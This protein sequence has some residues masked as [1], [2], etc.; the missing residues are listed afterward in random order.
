MQQNAPQSPAADDE[1]TLVELVQKIRAFFRRVWREKRVVVYCLLFTITI[2]LV[3]AFGSTK[4]YSAS[5]RIMPYRAASSSGGLGGLAGL[6]GIKIPSRG[7]EETV[8]PEMYPDIA[9]SLDFRMAMS[10]TPLYFRSLGDYVTPVTYFNEHAEPSFADGVK[11]YTIGLP[12]LV[13]GKVI[14]WFKSEEEVTG[15]GEDPTPYLAKYPK[16][17]LTLVSSIGERLTVEPEMLKGFQVI[18]SLKI[19]AT[20]PDPEAAAGLTKIASDQLMESVIQFEIRKI[21]GE[22]EYLETHHEEMEKRYHRAQAALAKFRDRTRNTTS[23]ATQ[24][25]MERLQNE[26]NMAFDLYRS[27]RSELEQARIK[28]NRDTPVFTVLENVVVP[29][30]PSAPRKV[31]ILFLSVFLGVFFGVGIIGFRMFWEQIKSQDLPEEPSE[32]EAS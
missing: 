22:L 1:I 29:N 15:T 23:A 12:K 8:Q 25:E 11:K 4:E 21:K 7:A 6:A 5:L 9:K 19:S 18:T 10:E 26:F 32:S 24:S 27:V 20:M 13:L 28:L 2:G 3:L 16:E 30:E 31:R 14:G 17:Y